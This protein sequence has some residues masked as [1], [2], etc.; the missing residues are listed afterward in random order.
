MDGDI[1]GILLAVGDTH[2]DLTHSDYDWGKHH[3]IA[4]Q[5]SSKREKIGS[6][7]KMIDP[8]E[9]SDGIA[10]SPSFPASLQGCYELLHFLIGFIYIRCADRG[11]LSGQISMFFSNQNTMASLQTILERPRL[12]KHGQK[13][14]M[15]VITNSQNERFPNFSG[16]PRYPKTAG[17]TVA[18]LHRPRSRR[19]RRSPAT[20]DT[21]W[22][23]NHTTLPALDVSWQAPWWPGH[24]LASSKSSNMEGLLCQKNRGWM[25]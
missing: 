22:H 25:C 7:E 2:S 4:P 21:A 14:H 20:M 16:S 13:P 17:C 11:C 12:W 15:P 23:R 9:N 6:P 19:S 1:S 18:P 3:G 24:P 10:T 5:I 8:L